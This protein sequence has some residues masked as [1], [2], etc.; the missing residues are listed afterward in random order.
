M[1][2]ITETEPGGEMVCILEFS[3]RP[4]GAENQPIPGPRRDFHIGERVRYVASFFKNTPADNPTGHMAVFE[5]L[6]LE[7][8]HRYVAT[9]DYFV[10][11]DCW[12]GLRE[13]F[14]TTSVRRGEP[15]EDGGSCDRP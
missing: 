11:L 6:D 1:S 9:R 5:P 14:A 10:T 4:R 12:E 13:H 15:E 2:A 8:E 3:A 7:D